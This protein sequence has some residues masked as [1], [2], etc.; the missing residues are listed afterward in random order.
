MIV[1]QGLCFLTLILPIIGYVLTAMLLKAI[2]WPGY[3]AIH[4][5]SGTLGT[6]LGAA[7]TWMI[8]LKLDGAGGTLLDPQTG[9][10]I[11]FEKRHTLIFIPIKY[12]AI[13]MAA[14]ALG[15]LFLQHDSSL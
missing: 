15:I 13:A 9:R 4:S 10:T 1:W 2:V 11:V 14:V 8:A 12:V 3:L 6:L 7:A 5:W